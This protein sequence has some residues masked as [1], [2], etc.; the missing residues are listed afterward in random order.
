M[1]IH[2]HGMDFASSS[3]PFDLVK[4]NFVANI[5]FQGPKRA[6]NQAKGSGDSKVVM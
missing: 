5:S 4:S 6:I 3:I 2:D 1:E